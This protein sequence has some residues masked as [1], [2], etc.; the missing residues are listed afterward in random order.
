MTRDER[1]AAELWSAPQDWA[2]EDVAAALW[3]LIRP[4]Q[5]M[6]ARLC[7]QAER[8]HARAPRRPRGHPA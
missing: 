7:A 5:D 2:T 6:A 8:T 1:T 4:L 3:R